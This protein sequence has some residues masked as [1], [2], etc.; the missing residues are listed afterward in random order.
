MKNLTFLLLY[1]TIAGCSVERNIE[2]KQDYLLLRFDSSDNSNY[3]YV[4][5]K[6]DTII[7]PGKYQLCFIDTFRTFAIVTSSQYPGYYAI[8]RNE[9]FLYNV[10]SLDGLPEYCDAEDGLFRIEQN[11]KI[12]FADMNG[13]IR[14]PAMY[15]CAYYFRD[16]K[17]KV[18]I[19][20]CDTIYE[21]EHISWKSNQWLYIDKRGRPVEE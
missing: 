1:L 3:W 15:A 10:L 21:G 18:S 9:R 11:G 14:I 7:P 6:G 5:V 13:E 17:A 12:G 16:G 19:L 2:D 8:D 4:N 20:P